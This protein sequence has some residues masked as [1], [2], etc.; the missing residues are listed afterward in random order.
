MLEVLADSALQA[1]SFPA[2][3][4]LSSGISQLAP[5]DLRRV[6]GAVLRTSVED[7]AIDS[8]HPANALFAEDDK[9]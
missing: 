2:Q 1:V 7:G 9:E 5:V 8:L 6:Q 3:D 4:F